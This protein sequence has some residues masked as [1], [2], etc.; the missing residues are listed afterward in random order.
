VWTREDR[1]GRL[2]AGLLPL[3]V[4]SC[5]V[6]DQRSLRPA[7][8][9]EEEWQVRGEGQPIDLRHEQ[10][11]TVLLDEVVQFGQVGFSEGGGDVHRSNSR[12]SVG[13][14][15]SGVRHLGLTGG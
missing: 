5:N 1:Q 6:T 9:V 7:C 3:R 4:R 12:V 11:E 2:T 15:P 13:L 10:A 8:P 14:C